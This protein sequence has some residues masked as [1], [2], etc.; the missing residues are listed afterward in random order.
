MALQ[1]LP[2]TEKVTFIHFS[3]MHYEFSNY[4]YYYFLNLY[5]MIFTQIYKEH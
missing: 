4:L 5:G 3:I 2:V 1:T